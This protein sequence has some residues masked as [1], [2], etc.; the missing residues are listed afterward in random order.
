M[1][2]TKQNK[3]ANKQTKNPSLMR[4][5]KTDNRETDK[6]DPTE[7]KSLQ[8]IQEC[9]EGIWKGKIVPKKQIINKCRICYLR[10]LL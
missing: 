1:N 9:K 6:S 2:T 4:N 5:P 7:V 3:K 10:G 8:I